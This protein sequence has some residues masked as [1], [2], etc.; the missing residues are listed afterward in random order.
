MMLF[1]FKKR[2][3]RDDF[4][5][6]PNICILFLLSSLSSRAHLNNVHACSGG[7]VQKIDTLEAATISDRFHE[8]YLIGVV[9]F[10][11]YTPFVDCQKLASNEYDSAL[12]YES[13]PFNHNVT[14]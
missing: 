4:D 14:H 11:N 10:L 2:L 8:T 12:F 7:A 5:T 9:V 1:C 13:R 3:S 6:R